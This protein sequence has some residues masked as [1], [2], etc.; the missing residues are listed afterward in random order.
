MITDFKDLELDKLNGLED[1][2]KMFKEK[3]DLSLSSC[4]EALE[5]ALKS[6]AEAMVP[7]IIN[8][9]PNG[10]YDM[11]LEEPEEILHFLT[12]EACKAENWV[13]QYVEQRKAGD[14]MLQL[15]FNNKAVDEG[16]VVRGIVYVGMSGKIRHA[17]VSAHT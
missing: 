14:Q 6:K 13:L 17:F 3:M 10:D 5:A 16:D 12:N 11:L 8:L 4:G 1:I 7:D 2:E 15:M 9:A